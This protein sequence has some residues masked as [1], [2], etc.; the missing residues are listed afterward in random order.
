MG[1]TGGEV[2]I[3]ALDD[4]RR[5][6]EPVIRS[7]L[8]LRVVAGK[9]GALE[10]FYAEHDVL[11][12]ARQFSGC[13]DAVLLRPAVGSPATYLVIADWDSADDYQRWVNDPWRAS[14][15]HELA[16]LLATGKDEPIVGGLFEFV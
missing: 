5:S 12:R 6:G 15:S 14:L 9:A 7:V 10:D 11:A 3:S 8:S 4:P 16:E 13:R 2:S 1:V